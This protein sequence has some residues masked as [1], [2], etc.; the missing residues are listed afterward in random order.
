MCI[1]FENMFKKHFKLRMILKYFNK[2]KQHFPYRIIQ[3]LS[4]FLHQKSL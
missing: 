2:N 3:T 1:I 4:A